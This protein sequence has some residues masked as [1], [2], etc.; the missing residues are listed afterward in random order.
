MRKAHFV[1]LGCAKNLVD[2]ESAAGLLG[3]SGWAISAFPEDADAVIINTCAFT[4]E[5][6]EESNEEIKALSKK[7]SP[8][9]KFI[10]CGCLAQ[11][12]KEKL[13]EQFP[14]ADAV[15]GSADYRHIC[16]ILQKLSASGAKRRGRV[17]CVG[18]ADFISGFSVPRLISTPRSYAYIKIAE[19]C[20]NHCSY[21]AIPSLR[22]EFRSRTENDILREAAA[23]AEMGIRELIL[24]ANDSA[25]YLK[26]PR[27]R[28]LGGLL[29]KL[30]RISAIRRIRILYMHPAHISEELINVIASLP[31]VARYFD[32]PIQHT[33]DH[34]LARMGRS[35]FSE[36][37]ALIDMIRKHIPAA[38]LR[39]TFITGFPGETEKR[40]NKLTQDL[41]RLKF[42]WAGVFAYSPEKGTAAYD[43]SGRP[44]AAEALSRA[45]RLMEIQRKISFEFS[46]GFA[47][48]RLEVIADSPLAGRTE[49]Q[50]PGVDGEVI[51][52][53]KQRPGAMK[54]MLIRSSKGYDLLA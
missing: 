47:G 18:K 28:A 53:K 48:K 10:I 34:I 5:A 23:L 1:S 26:D 2:S 42:S 21:C 30:H 39:T 51:F 36:T 12:E 14:R 20:S 37:E 31:K 4:R 49:F 41:K 25:F 6:R 17:L 16:S 22:G 27:G 13:F 44:S 15:A 33:D 9:A 46:R 24:I 54:K 35:P 45:K 7:I 19:G 43:M 11:K 29:K 3:S 38:A 40:F 50:S 52:T 32:I 8:D